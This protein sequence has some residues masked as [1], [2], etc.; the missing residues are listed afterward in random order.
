MDESLSAIA[1]LQAG[2]TRVA[3]AVVRIGF[4]SQ[5]T[6]SAHPSTGSGWAL[7]V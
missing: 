3:D 6:Q 4:S 5:G 2:R 7:M 1:V